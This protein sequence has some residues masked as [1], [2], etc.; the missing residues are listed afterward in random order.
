MLADNRPGIGDTHRRYTQTDLPGGRTDLTLPRILRTGKHRGELWCLTLPWV[1]AGDLYTGIARW[2]EVR[3]NRPTGK[4]SLEVAPTTLTTFF[5]LLSWT[6]TFRPDLG[7][8]KMNQHA[9]YL[10]NFARG[11]LQGVVLSSKFYQNCLTGFWDVRVDIFLSD[12]PLAYVTG[13]MVQTL[14]S[15]VQKLLSS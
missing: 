15:L 14:R 12:W 1:L 3:V 10:S 11:G 13:C 8:M 2:Q 5:L 4:P 9:I 7:T 6:L